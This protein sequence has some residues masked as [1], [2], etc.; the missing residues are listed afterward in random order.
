MTAINDSNTGRSTAVADTTIALARF[1]AFVFDLDGVITRTARLHA[2]AW[3]KMF[4]AFLLKH[5]PQGRTVK[6]FDIEADYLHYVDG[7]P[8][9]DGVRSFLASRGIKLPEGDPQDALDQD[10]VCGLGNRKDALY[11]QAL[12]SGAVEVYESS[13]DLLRTLRKAGIRTAV[14]SSSRNCLDVLKAAGIVSLFDAR[15]DGVELEQKQMAGKPAPDMF[16]EASRR[17]DADP[18]RCVGVEDAMAGVQAIKSAGFG[19]VIG[20]DRGHQAQALREH[21][22]DVVVDDLGKLE[23]VGAGTKT[24][25]PGYLPSA[26]DRLSEIIAA[27]TREPALFL[28][29]D[30]TLTP[31]V[32]HPDDAILSDAMRATLR[33]LSSRCPIAIVSGRD[34]HDVR[35]R[36]G[37]E[38]IWYAGSHGFDISGPRGKHSEFPGGRA[39]LPALDAAEQA[40]R[41]Q[42][43]SI[44]RCLVERKRFS[45]ATHYRQVAPEAVEAVKDVVAKIAAAHPGLRMKAGKKVVELQPDVDWDKGKALRWLMRALGLDPARFVPVYIGDDVTDEDAFRELADD[46]VTVLVAA[47][48]G[49]TRAAYRLDDPGAVQTFLDRLGEALQASRS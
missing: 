25:S 37:I 34:L 16:I 8:R 26:P 17:L 19:L 49:P 47:E 36:V 44:P 41:K 32:P 7:K 29:Y 23:V 12:R 3:K 5:T 15:V 35:N 4:D 28:D 6:P 42:L 13:V 9:Y 33:Q 31:I 11:R 14:V 30:G 21:G 27:D 48:D 10:T 2:A 38:D 40:L 20:V 45:I 1:D 39:Y 43:A 46:G 24:A 18:P 22:A